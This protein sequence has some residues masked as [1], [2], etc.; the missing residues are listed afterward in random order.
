MNPFL[1]EGMETNRW[2]VRSA[3][4]FR[5]AIRTCRARSARPTFGLNS[6]GLG[7]LGE[8]APPN[9]SK[10]INPTV[11]STIMRHFRLA[12]AALGFATTVDA[13]SARPD[14]PQ[15]G[16]PHGDFVLP[17]ATAPAQW[18][19]VRA[20]NIVWRVT[21]PETGQSPVTVSGGR[22]FFSHV[23]PVEADSTVGRHTIACC[24]DAATGKLLWQREIAGRFDLR[25]SGCFSD[26]SSPPAVT[27]G[28]TVCFI[29]ASGTIAS[30]D[31]AGKLRWS[32]DI[33]VAGRT[34]PFVHQGRII[35]L[36]QIYPPDASGNFT[37]DH[38]HAPPEEW[39]QLQALDLKTG[40]VVWTTRCG[41]NMGS[42]SLPQQRTDG[43]HV[44]VVGRGGGHGPPETPEG[45]SLV[46][47]GDGR[48]LWSL[49]IE[50]FM[51]TMSFSL[52]QGNVIV[53]HGAECWKV[54]AMTGAITTRI[55]IV[56]RIRARLH[57]DDGKWYVETVTIKE[58]KAGREITQGSNLLV[59][60][61]GFFRSYQRNYLGRVN[62]I[63]GQVEYLML[64]VQM[65]REPG[66]DDRLLWGPAGSLPAFKPGKKAGPLA[67][68]EWALRHNQV[69]NSR[70]LLVMGDERS[71]G[72]GW[73]HIASPSP[74]AVGELL[75]VTSM[76]G[77]VYVVHWRAERLDEKAL[78]A[79]NDL[80]PLGDAWTRAS[81][82]YAEGRL[83][84]QTIREVIA[85]GDR[86]KP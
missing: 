66:K 62:L 53:F 31:F 80:G 30:F 71:Q 34:I 16:G 3:R 28:D 42:L 81:L 22:A 78:V 79:I 21:L 58:G 51:S 20:E 48:T 68:H 64:P 86:P 45:I 44:A 37:P 24:A 85:I 15:G 39:T 74:I 8:P 40:E 59:G 33:L 70:G 56:D 4:G 49:P 54:D 83:Y 36:R 47:L 46:D 35:Y 23:K 17:G 41:A 12:A 57:G 14:W 65:L 43:K 84:A 25:L 10:T 29:N 6:Y 63:T 19:V 38:A 9:K 82:S 69:R 27:F 75:Y 11:A 7:P 50:G 2:A 67:L 18:S 72:N 5:Y 60:D 73:G 76:S 26:S 13:E 32:K 52:H 55:K 61:H 1:L 77:L